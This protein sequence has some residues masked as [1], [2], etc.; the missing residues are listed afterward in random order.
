MIRASTSCGVTRRSAGIQAVAAASL[1]RMVRVLDSGIDA[2][3]EDLA[4]N[5]C[6]T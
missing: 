4:R 1:P 5:V 3:H 6:C 2:H